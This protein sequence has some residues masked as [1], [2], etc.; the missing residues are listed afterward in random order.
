M[1]LTIKE[2]HVRMVVEE[3]S[4]PDQGTSNSN[5]APVISEDRLIQKCIEAVLQIL[6]DKNEH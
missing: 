4:N 6:E 5:I 1:P 3:N 2:L